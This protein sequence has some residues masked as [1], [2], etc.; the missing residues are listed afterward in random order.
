MG[1]IRS[2]GNRFIL[3]SPTYSIR[4]ITTFET[5][6]VLVL[7][8]SG[9]AVFLPAYL[10]SRRDAA[11]LECSLRLAV[12]REAKRD[13][14]KEMNRLLPRDK[15]LRITDRINP[16]HA[17]K[18]AYLTMTSPFRFHPDDPGPLGGVISIGTTFLDPPSCSLGHPI[19][20]LDSFKESKT[21]P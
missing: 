7:I 6:L 10:A 8:V 2:R 4:G 20:D 9:I 16:L 14:M 21:S 13:V 1:E 11:A 5:L 17:D 3:R 19:A 15:R 12:I 18:I